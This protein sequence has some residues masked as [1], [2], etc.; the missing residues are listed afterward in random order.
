MSIMRIRLVKPQRA[1]DHTHTVAFEV[2]QGNQYIGGC[3]RLCD[4]GLL[5]EIPLWNIDTVITGP[6]VAVGNDERTPESGRCV[7]V[8]LCGQQKVQLGGS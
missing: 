8:A 4:V 2:S 1:S 5:E 6:D 7:A 3:D